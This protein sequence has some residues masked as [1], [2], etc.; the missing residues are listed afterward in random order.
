MGARKGR[1]VARNAYITFSSRDKKTD[2]HASNAH[3]LCLSL[4]IPFLPPRLP[5][6]TLHVCRPS[7]RGRVCERRR[8]YHREARPLKTPHTPT[9]PTTSNC[10]RSNGSSP[11]RAVPRPSPAHARALARTT[12]VLSFLPT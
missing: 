7:V 11:Q 10:L 3:P 8:L 1:K 2:C 9:T 5:M 12:L 4:L 6:S